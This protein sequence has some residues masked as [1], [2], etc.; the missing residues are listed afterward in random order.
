M[1]SESIFSGRSLSRLKF[2]DP[3]VLGTGARAIFSVILF[4][5]VMSLH[6]SRKCRLSTNQNTKVV[7][8]YIQTVSFAQTE[9]KYRALF[10]KK[11][12]LSHHTISRLTQHFIPIVSVLE[13]RSGRKPVITNEHIAA[14]KAVEEDPTISICRLAQQVNLTKSATQRILRKKT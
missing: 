4:F 10:G 3:A 1:E 14:K 8:F 2:V 5:P 11:L 7:Q 13:P 12:T 9:R 6:V